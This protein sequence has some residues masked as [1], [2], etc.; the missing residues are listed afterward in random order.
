MGGIVSTSVSA[1]YHNFNAFIAKGFNVSLVTQF[2]KL[3]C[4]LIIRNG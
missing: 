2:I 4:R 3:I 1:A